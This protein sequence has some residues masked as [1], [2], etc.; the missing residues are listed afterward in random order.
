M[1][2]VCSQVL[3]VFAPPLFK[4]GNRP[5]IIQ[6]ININAGF[7]DF[8]DL[9]APGPAVAVPDCR[10]P[11]ELAFLNKLGGIDRYVFTFKQQFSTDIGDGQSYQDA[12]MIEHY[13][14]RGQIH[15]RVE[16]VSQYLSLPHRL[17]LQDLLESVQ[18]W[19]IRG[20]PPAPGYPDV[21]VWVPVKIDSG[22]YLKYKS[23]DRQT[24]LT[25]SFSYGQLTLVQSQ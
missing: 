13:S 23:N 10:F 9:P 8:A 22:S 17:A 18:V 24:Q 2:V 19:E 21:R 20:T 7:V 14:K 15:Q 12:S 3:T 5:C 16:V 6:F 4:W 11:I 1:T 25:F